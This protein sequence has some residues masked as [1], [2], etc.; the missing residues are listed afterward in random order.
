LS[1]VGA[2]A[3][4][5]NIA[6]FWRLVAIVQLRLIEMLVLVAFIGNGIGFSWAQAFPRHS[7]Y[8]E[9]RFPIEA[10]C[11]FGL[12]VSL[13]VF[14]LLGG[15]TSALAIAARL[16]VDEQADRFCLMFLFVLYPFAIV[17]GPTCAIFTY[18]CASVNEAA[19]FALFFSLTILSIVL[20]TGARHVR[21]K[22]SP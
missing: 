2:G 16:K 12:L 7:H 3:I 20:V 10:I 8:G 11:I 17:G 5:A 1:V 19:Y 21:N 13:F 4:L 6:V 18:V 22:P 15:V 14:L 9:G